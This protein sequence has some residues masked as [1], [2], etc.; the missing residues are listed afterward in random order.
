MPV[1]GNAAPTRQARPLVGGEFLSRNQL[2]GQM[3][4][5]QWK[6]PVQ[7]GTIAPEKPSSS[8]GIPA[9]NSLDPEK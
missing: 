8:P 9:Y 4:F 3:A 1:S 2:L 5:Y 6:Q 7:L